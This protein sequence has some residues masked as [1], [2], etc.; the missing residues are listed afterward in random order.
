MALYERGFT[1]LR[2]CGFV[3]ICVC[4]A[5][6]LLA[7]A[8]ACQLTVGLLPPRSTSP[9]ALLPWWESGEGSVYLVRFVTILPEYV[10]FYL[11]TS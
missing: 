6:Y 2:R 8:L 10:R 3:Q 11:A 1:G 4:L 5:A 9:F 7:S